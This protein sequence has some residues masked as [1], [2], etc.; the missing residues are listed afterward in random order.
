MAARQK[1]DLVLLDV[2][3]PDMSG[4]EVCKRL[5]RD[6]GQPACLVLQITASATSAEHATKAL[7]GGADADVTE[8]IDPDVLVAT[9]RAMLRLQEAERALTHANRQLEIANR[10]LVRSNADLAHF[11][12]AASHDLQEPLRTI[13][14]FSEMVEASAR[15][16]LDERE[17]EHF[18]RVISSAA[19]MRALISDLLAYSQIGREAVTTSVVNLDEVVTWAISNLREGIEESAARIEMEKKLPAVLGDFSQ[20][21]QVFQ[22][23]ISNA[24]KYRQRS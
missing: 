4:Y 17:R 10:E 2:H 13:S 7:D 24:L 19:R 9:V 3:L 23:L 6:L 21:V 12:F 1:P 8:P 11:A 14:I 15:A 22:N 20:L 5:K 16:K 18:R